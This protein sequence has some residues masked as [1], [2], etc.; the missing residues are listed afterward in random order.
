MPGEQRNTVLE[1]RFFGSRLLQRRNKR[2]R[3]PEP[4][5]QSKIASMH[6]KSKGSW[7]AQTPIT[8]PHSTRNNSD[9]GHCTR[10]MNDEANLE[11]C[12]PRGVV[13]GHRERAS[14]KKP[15]WRRHGLVTT[16]RK[17]ASRGRNDKEVVTRHLCKSR[18]EGI[19]VETSLEDISQ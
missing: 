3:R 7:T 19:V 13:K 15:S 4:T 11:L 9:G 1:T 14:V 18:R 6:Q 16:V 17:P 8:R 12:S 2:Y 10:C 5:A